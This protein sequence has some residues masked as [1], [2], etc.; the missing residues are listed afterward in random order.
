[1]MKKQVIST[2]NVL[3]NL[4]EIFEAE[5]ISKVLLVCDAAFEYLQTKEEYLKKGRV[6]EKI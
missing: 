6:R 2:T 3:G 1:M 4:N 5:G